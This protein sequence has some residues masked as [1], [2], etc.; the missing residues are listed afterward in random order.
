VFDDLI[1][2]WKTRFW[3]P[4]ARRIGW[5]H[6]HAMSLIAWLIGLACAAA[7]A[8]GQYLLALLLWWLN[9][10]ADGLDGEL[11][12]ASGRNS[13]FGGYLDIVLDVSIYALVPAALVWADPQPQ[14]LGALALLLATFYLNGISWTYLS[15]LLEK[16]RS[17]PASITSVH[18]PAGLVAGT[19]SVIFYSAFLIFPQ[20]L[21]LGFGAMAALVALTV[22]Q[23][24]VWAWRHL[25]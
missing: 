11:A 9:R 8:Q 4:V 7:A 14:H 23:R 5:L 10:T 17:A 19:E 22:L 18:M 20:F 25:R 1:R 24:L 2:G 3:R 13:D 16:R 15:A 6:P 21:V 12:R